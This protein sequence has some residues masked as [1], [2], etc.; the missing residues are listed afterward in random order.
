MGAFI[1]NYQVRSEA[2]G[3]V[4]DALAPLIE[5][6][7]YVSP[8]KNGW[9]TVY[10]E[11]SDTQ[12]ESVIRKLATHLS[13][14][15]KTAVFA[16]MVHDSDVLAYWL[17]ENG[18]LLDEFNSRP[19]YF[20]ADVDE[21]TCARLRGK[22]EVLVR[23]CVPGTTRDQVVSVLQPPDG[24]FLFAEQALADVTALL[25]IDDTRITL[26]FE[27]FEAEGSEILDNV[28]EFEPVGSGT[29]RKA[30]TAV[31]RPASPH[32]ID[33]FLIAVGMLTQE[34]GRQMQMNLGAFGALVGSN[35][36]M[37]K[38]RASSERIARDALK[39]SGLPGLPSFD[40]LKRARDQ[41]PDALAELLVRRT[42]DQITDIGITAAANQV[43]DFIAAL[44]RHGLDPN[45]R[46]INGTTPLKTA[47]AHGTN[48]RTYQLLK[49]AAE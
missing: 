8:P 28:D 23:F 35:D 22:A 16:F 40:E 13:K 34:W 46:N 19:D 44:L 3:A 12:S 45:A 41:G 24:E 11:G 1:V 31:A 17:Y 5:S 48:T 42:P 15:L 33:P 2:A 49:A 25:G 9:V 30:R 18:E 10:D 38:L 4:R 21:A 6:R 26:G 27:Y 47:Q 14:A 37:K 7:A 43:E 36:M 29:E 39:G 20:D 32:I